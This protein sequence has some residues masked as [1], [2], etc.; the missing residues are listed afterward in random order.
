MWFDPGMGDLLQVT[1]FE[2]SSGRD[3]VDLSECQDN[4][5]YG[6]SLKSAETSR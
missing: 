4:Q 3:K 6:A 1:D 2:L 5:F